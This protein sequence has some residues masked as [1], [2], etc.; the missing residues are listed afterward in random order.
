MKRLHRLIFLVLLIT[1]LAA[2]GIATYAGGGGTL[3]KPREIPT[4]RAVDV[5]I[6]SSIQDGVDVWQDG[7]Y[8]FVFMPVDPSNPLGVCDDAGDCGD[9]IEEVCAA[10]GS[11]ASEVTYKAIEKKCSGACANGQGIDTT[12]SKPK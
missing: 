8:D 11:E 9:A 6:A 12:C 1:A 2:F 4:K 7:A 5:F 10:L 3:L